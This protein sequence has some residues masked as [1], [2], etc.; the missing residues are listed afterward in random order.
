ME[1][2]STLTLLNGNTIRILTHGGDTDNRLTV[3]DYIDFTQGNP[4][5]F[6]RHEFIEVFTVLEGSLCFQY[7][8]ESPFLVSA[9]ESE[10]VSS[11][12]SHTFWN[13][14]K[15]PLRILLCC[16]PAGLERFFEDIHAEMEKLKTGKLQES[17]IPASMEKLRI[18]HGIEETAPAPDINN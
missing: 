15:E 10:T 18:R 2:D 4:P 11:G 16:S 12:M 6:T 9:G 5:P 13:P 17:D 1:N 8:G 3:I 7:L 14:G